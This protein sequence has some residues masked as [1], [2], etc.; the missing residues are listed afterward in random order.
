[1]PKVGKGGMI[2]VRG[3]GD[4]RLCERI[5]AVSENSV[6]RK[7]ELKQSF[8]LNDEIEG[9]DNGKNRSRN[10]N[11]LKKFHKKSSNNFSIVKI[12]IENCSEYNSGKISNKDEDNDKRDKDFDISSRGCGGKN[13]P[14]KQSNEIVSKERDKRVKNFDKS[15]TKFLDKI[16]TT[17]TSTSTLTQKQKP[18]CSPFKKLSKSSLTIEPDKITV[19]LS[20][21]SP[22]ASRLAASSK[23]ISSKNSPTSPESPLRSVAGGDSKR[24]LKLSSSSSLSV[25]GFSNM[26]NDD[27]L[28]RFE[29]SNT[30][31]ASLSLN[32]KQ[33][34]QQQQQENKYSSNV[35]CCPTTPRSKSVGDSCVTSPISEGTT[36]SCSPT[37]TEIL[38]LEDVGF[39]NIVNDNINFNYSPPS[40]PPPPPP[41]PLP[42]PLPLNLER[43]LSKNRKKSLNFNKDLNRGNGLLSSKQQQ[44]QKN[45]NFSSK[46][47]TRK[48]TLETKC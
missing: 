26:R 9:T 34:Q 8:E 7:S 21:Y 28:S 42:L 16:S 20:K 10:M 39:S 45:S 17:S 47:T 32:I 41:P 12:Q 44:Q 24:E 40:P 15:G 36:I 13:C 33:F 4:E 2:I 19:N 38:S 22:C 35:S 18:S 25:G 30:I 1:M 3:D 37:G 11:N 5:R 27:C 29:N 14:N 23:I 48:T 6:T 31:Q 43:E 46:K